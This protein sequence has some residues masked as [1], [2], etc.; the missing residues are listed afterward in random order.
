MAR[1]LLFLSLLPAVLITISCGTVSPGFIPPVIQG[2]YE[3]ITASEGTPGAAA[4]LEVNF[5]QTDEVLS[6]SKDNVVIIQ[7]DQPLDLPIILDSWGGPCDNGKPGNNFL[8]GAF[9]N[10]TQASFA[11]TES[12]GLG[13]GTSI[14]NVT[15]SSDG[16][17]ITNGTYTSPAQCGFG[18][19]NGNLIGTTIKPFSGRYAGRISNTSGTTDL[20]MVTMNQSGFNLTVS[21]TDDGTN[22]SLTGA[23][24]GATFDVSGSIAGRA[25]RYFGLY[26]HVTDEFRVFDPAL[27]FIGL[28][29]GGT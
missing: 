21:G 18:A 23:V 1:L 7:I 11:L 16:T 4:L 24:V 17:Q 3:I 14:A 12:G 10:A 22:F 27:T 2:Q 15:V 9:S 13:T 19:D 25:V 8:R 6:A 26:N 20:V 5:T 29:Q 28:L